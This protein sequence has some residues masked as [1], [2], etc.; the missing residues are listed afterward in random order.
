MHTPAQQSHTHRALQCMLLAG[1]FL[2]LPPT[3]IAEWRDI[4][5]QLSVSAGRGVYDRVQ[6]QYL[7]KVT[8]T[9]PGGAIGGPLQLVL[10]QSNMTPTN[11]D[12][13]TDNT[14]PLADAPYLSLGSI[15]MGAHQS[16]TE[17]LQFRR[18]R[19]RLHYQVRVLNDPS[20]APSR[21]VSA[22]LSLPRDGVDLG[23]LPAQA[24]DPS[25]TVLASTHTTSSGSFQLHFAAAPVPDNYRITVT[26]NDGTELAVEVRDSQRRMH[27]VNGLTTMVSRYARA[28]TDLPLEAVERRVATLLQI[29][30]DRD[31]GSGLGDTWRS[32]FS[33]S[34]F[35]EAARDTSLNDFINVHVLAIDADETTAYRKPDPH[36]AIHRLLGRDF[37]FSTGPNA[38]AGVAMEE[39]IFAPTGGA[40]DFAVNVLGGVV[41]NVVTG[42]VKGSIGAIFEAC[43]INY[44]EAEIQNEL[45]QIES[46][47]DEVQSTVDAIQTEVQEVLG[48]LDEIEQRLILQFDDL[49]LQ[50]AQQT[51]AEII[52]RV[53]SY[54]LDYYIP[55]VTAINQA[56]TSGQQ[57]P[58]QVF[59][60]PPAAAQTFVA[61]MRDYSAGDMMSDFT[62]LND[63]MLGTGGQPCLPLLLNRAMANRLGSSNPAGDSMF[64][65]VRSNFVLEELMDASDYYR[66][67]QI[68]LYNLISEY[69]H[70]DETSFP[71]GSGE[72]P[73]NVA[74]DNLN[75]LFEQMQQLSANLSASLQLTPTP[76]IAQDDV[77]IVRG[78]MWYPGF[79][80]GVMGTVS[81]PPNPD[82]ALGPWG[83]SLWGFLR[84]R[85][86]RPCVR[87][88]KNWVGVTRSLDCPN[89]AS[90][91]MH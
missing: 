87:W 10:V 68:L 85:R 18:S 62:A 20:L 35:V 89:S 38:E 71:L 54:Y 82:F 41:G 28:H 36:P 91:A 88:P 27:W 31:L 3:V 55:G 23:G 73:S 51:A 90:S 66:A 24:V 7:A 42:L 48:E 79:L 43:G 56:M 1:L 81:A 32:P 58:G 6:R 61:Q 52:A 29:P 70:I 80:D 25:G 2:L 15:G 69:R 14:S 84:K 40:I 30:E 46:T 16:F 53:K 33:W 34:A 65:D 63:L 37:S 57:T 59:S 44:G 8:V 22:R 78:S 11:A 64:I 50:E 83:Q 12:G 9:N 45:G 77:I 60:A 72:P 26:Q 75:S 21:F 17:T 39:G 76:T 47:L 67:Y 19:G 4:T 5:D 86:P 49:A 13:L 74:P